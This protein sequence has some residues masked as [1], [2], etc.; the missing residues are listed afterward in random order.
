MAAKDDNKGASLPEGWKETEEDAPVEKKK[1][2]LHI[3]NS[4]M[5]IIF[6]VVLLGFIALPLLGRAPHK[7]TSSVM[8][9]GINVSAEG[10]PITSL[11]GLLSGHID[12]KRLDE[13]EDSNNA[14]NEILAVVG[15]SS[16]RASSGRK[17]LFAGI[18]GTTGITA[19]GS[20]VRI[21]GADRAGLWKAVWV[22][23]SILSDA[24]ITSSID[25]FDL[26]Y[27]VPTHSKAYL[28]QDMEGTCSSYGHIISAEGDIL[29]SL[30]YKQAE[31]GGELFHYQRDAGGCRFMN[32]TTGASSL[33]PASDRD[34][35][36]V[37][38]RKGNSTVITVSPDYIDFQYKDCSTV[39][40]V[41]VILRDMICPNIIS[42]LAKF[43]MPTEL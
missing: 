24:T 21:E 37:T 12:G 15:Q 36:I 25:L 18:T 19:A 38:M 1:R 4:V 28:I 6:V 40:S 35:F 23:N 27:A 43:K 20:E 14:L 31:A 33:C 22:F 8:V 9:N 2:E 42:E 13:S 32:D 39:D 30:A 5:W 3:S 7:P 29:S 11:K 17:T 34:K 41:S 26:Q 10:D 16:A